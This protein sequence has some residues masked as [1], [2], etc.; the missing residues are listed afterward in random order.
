MFNQKVLLIGPSAYALD[1]FDYNLLQNYDYVARTNGFLLYRS[2]LKTI[3]DRCDMIF[4]NSASFKQY[5]KEKSLENLLGKIVYTK[6]HGSEEYLNKTYG[7][8]AL[9]CICIYDKVEEVRLQLEKFYPNRIPIDFQPYTGTVA[10]AYLIEQY[11]E[12]HVCGMDFYESGFG[13]KGIYVDSYNAYN[14]LDR[15]EDHHR[16]NKDMAF[17]IDLQ[18]QN[19][20]RLKFLGKT[21]EILEESKWKMQRRWSWTNF[22]KK[23]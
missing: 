8:D 5:K 4:I 23:I 3:E 7:T 12:V 1:G 18:L 9:T 17:L 11:Q 10:I 20:E 6:I 16:M 14:I 19:P 13:S 15:Q 22:Y 21:Q 2:E